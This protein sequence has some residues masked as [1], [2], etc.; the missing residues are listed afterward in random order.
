MYVRIHF[1]HFAVLFLLSIISTNPTLYLSPCFQIHFCKI[2]PSLILPI[3]ELF[4]C[5][6]SSLLPNNF[7]TASNFTQ[8][9]PFST[10]NSSKCCPDMA[11]VKSVYAYFILPKR[12]L[13]AIN[14]RQCVYFSEKFICYLILLKSCLI[15][16]SCLD[17]PLLLLSSLVLFLV[18]LSKI[19]VYTLPQSYPHLPQKNVSCTLDSP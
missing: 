4:I 8:S 11:A 7:G 16:C 12:L 5:L 13:Q 1:N 17:L 9:L 14:R 19:P 6:F 15:Y 2:S 10:T 18:G 3:V